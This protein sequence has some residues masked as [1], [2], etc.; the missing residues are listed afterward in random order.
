M[1]W[2][3]TTLQPPQKKATTTYYNHLKNIYNHSQRIE[4]HLKQAIIH[5]LTHTILYDVSYP[6]N[7][8]FDVAW[9]HGS[10][11]KHGCLRPLGFSPDNLRSSL[12]TS[13]QLL[14]GLP[15]VLRPSTC[16]ERTLPVHDS[17]FMTFVWVHDSWFMTFVWHDLSGWSLLLKFSKIKN[18]GQKKFK[19]FQGP[20]MKGRDFQRLSRVFKGFK[21]RT[22]PVCSMTMAI[23]CLIAIAIG[24]SSG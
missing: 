5:S 18:A 13:Q 11:I 21:T 16:R 10:S 3:K 24:F 20:G 2:A 19:D 12:R 1:E 4:Y 23:E 6:L 22:N 9:L 17:W 7:R 15:W 14:Q 8:G